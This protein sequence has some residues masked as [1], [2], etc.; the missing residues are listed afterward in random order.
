MR[1]RT[2][3]IAQNLLKRGFQ[4]RQRFSFMTTINDDLIPAF[5]AT[6]YLACPIVPLHSLLSQR[7]IRNIL[8]KTKPLVL[9]CDANSYNGIKEILKKLTWNVK[10][11]IFGERIDGLEPFENLLVETGEESNFV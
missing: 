6:I 5:V 3:R 1:L 8:E 11:F 7:D 9:F 10:V 4:P 2:I